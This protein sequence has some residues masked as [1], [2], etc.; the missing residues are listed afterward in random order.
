MPLHRRVPKRGFT[1]KWR[2]EY[3]AVNLE[4]LTI[5]DAGTIVTPD[6]L[7]KRGMIKNL[8][9]GLKVLGD[10]ELKQAL[11]VRAHKFSAGAQKKITAAGG[12]AEVIETKS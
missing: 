7:L 8:R 2:K 5:F 4:K 6:L 3:A 10:G 9:D 12:K 11:T 1:N